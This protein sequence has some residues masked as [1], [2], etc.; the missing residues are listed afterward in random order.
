GLE[1]GLELH[2]R[3]ARDRDDRAWRAED[4][5]HAVWRRDP[6]RDEARPPLRVRRDRAAGAGV[7]VS[8][9]GLLAA[10]ASSWLFAAA[11]AAAVSEPAGGGADAPAIAAD[12]R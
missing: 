11:H 3:T 7:R 5:L 6:H 10:L 8:R 2:R 1:Q 12:T 4:R 9:R